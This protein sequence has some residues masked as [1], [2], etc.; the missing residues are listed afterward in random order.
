MRNYITALVTCLLAG[1]VSAQS[2]STKKEKQFGVSVAQTLSSYPGYFTTGLLA[3]YR[4]HKHQLE[5]G[6]KFFLIDRN[7]YNQRFGTEFNYR[8]YPNGVHNRFNLFFLLNADYIHLYKI[9][10]YQQYVSSSNQYVMVNKKR[11]DNDLTM[12]IGYGFHANLFKGLYIG[13]NIGAGI[14]LERSKVVRNSTESSINSTNR[15]NN[16]ALSFLLTVTLGYRF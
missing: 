4:I 6:P 5:F 3:T 16:M 13:N 10:D 14:L 9:S 11:R 2:D 1:I 7:Y 12:N 15:Y 8:Y